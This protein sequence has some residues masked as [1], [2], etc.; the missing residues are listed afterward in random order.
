MW[1][2][3]LGMEHGVTGETRETRGRARRG[4]DQAGTEARP[5][6]YWIL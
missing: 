5:T 2:V 3:K 1:D 4:K 6:G